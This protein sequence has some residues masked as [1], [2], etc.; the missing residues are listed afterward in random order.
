MRWQYSDLE[1][2]RRNRLILL[3]VL[4]ILAMSVLL[5]VGPTSVAQ[6]IT[7]KDLELS[8]GGLPNAS[9]NA[10][11][12][13]FVSSVIVSSVIITPSSAA[14]SAVFSLVLSALL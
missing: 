12:S 8:S 7:L 11:R 14:V 4:V 1:A 2:R 3:A 6:L 13:S 9:R 10:K 5:L